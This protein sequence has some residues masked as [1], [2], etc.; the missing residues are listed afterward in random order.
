MMLVS[1]LLVVFLFLLS[2]NILASNIECDLLELNY[3][4][5]NNKINEKIRACYN[6]SG[7]KLKLTSD[8]CK[9]IQNCKM[10]D[11]LNREMLSLGDVF[12]STGSPVFNLCHAYEWSPKIANINIRGEWRKIVICYSDNDKEY[13]SG[14]YL[15][16][17]LLT[18]HE[19]K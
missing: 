15:L 11:K 9:D 19:K 17:L 12:S 8:K 5:K 1:R 13:V 16:D 2:G 3:I 4:Y 10:I 6:T 14:D 7:E 18:I